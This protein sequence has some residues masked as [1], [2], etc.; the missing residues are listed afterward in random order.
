[1]VKKR[2]FALGLLSTLVFGLLVPLQV[3]ANDGEDDLVDEEAQ[4]ED[5]TTGDDS[6][7]DS[8]DDED[9]VE[10]EDES[11]VESGDNENGEN[12][13]GEDSE[14]DEGEDDFE[15]EVF[16]SDED[17][18]AGTVS[19]QAEEEGEVIVQDV[20]KDDLD[21]TSVEDFKAARDSGMV[22]TF[23]LS[24]RWGYFPAAGETRPDLAV[25]DWDGTIGFD[26]ET[27]ALPVKTLRFEKNEDEIDF[28]ATTEEETT[29]HSDIYNAT[30]GILFKV[31]ADMEG[32]HE[33]GIENI[34]CVIFRA[35]N[36]VLGGLRVSLP[37]LL[38]TMGEEYTVQDGDYQVVLKI[39][40]SD[41]WVKGEAKTQEV[42]EGVADDAETGSWYEDYMNQSIGLGFFG[43]DRHEDGRPMGTIRPGDGITRFELLKVASEL[44]YRLD[45]GLGAGSCDP[46]TVTIDSAAWMGDHWAKGYVQ[47][48]ENSDL[49]VQLLTDVIA[50]DVSV[51]NEKALRKEVAVT[52]LEVLDITP[53][54]SAE[55][56]FTDSSELS[57]EEEDFVNLLYDLDVVEGYSDGH[58][59]P[60]TNVNRA[61]MFK[62]VTL[63]H[64]VMSL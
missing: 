6:G 60:D 46:E 62:I 38:E 52:M 19:A 12:S 50:Q 34:P 55:V 51:G 57:D 14:G 28:S 3:F 39:W 4:T 1:M 45:L 40:T 56:I 17:V 18:E 43:G 53:S 16:Y 61:E 30:D 58:F 26:N 7:D 11:V 13:D 24:V 35:N 22:K 49:D 37:Y 64:E 31:K 23:L 27:V 15:D 47:C 10:S 36:S 48:L 41:E 33:N 59:G 2:T 9:G 8:V 54:N 42:E 21:E 25:T 44:A 5:D 29:F 32:V 20:E 63:L